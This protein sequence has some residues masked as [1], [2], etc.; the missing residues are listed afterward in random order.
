MP[1]ITITAYRSVI[2]DGNGNIVG[3]SNIPIGEANGKQLLTGAGTALALP[4]ETAYI[5]VATDTAIHLKVDG[6][7]AATTD[8]YLPAGVEYFGAD[9][10]ATPSIILG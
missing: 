2:T 5:R 7:G 9:E 1:K 4:D 3:L 6:A 10:G 8:P